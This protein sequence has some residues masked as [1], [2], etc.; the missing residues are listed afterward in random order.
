MNVRW[1]AGFREPPADLDGERAR[2]LAVLAAG[3]STIA[4]LL[5]GALEVALARPVLMH[6][7]WTGAVIGG[8]GRPDRAGQ[9]RVG[10]VDGGGVM[11]PAWPLGIGGRLVIGGEIVFVNR[12]DGAEV[13]GFTAAGAP[14]RFV[15]TRADAEAT[16]EPGGEGLRSGRCS[17]TLAR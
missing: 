15:L 9:S 2:M 14:V 7:L 5:S 8:C 13:H 3:P 1:L 4:E 12:V 10:A 16:A 6:L 11:E 17:W